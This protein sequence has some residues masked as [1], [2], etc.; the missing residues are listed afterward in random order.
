VIRQM[1]AGTDKKELY[2]VV[3]RYKGKLGP[4]ATTR[5]LNEYL[6]VRRGPPALPLECRTALIPSPV[7][8]MATG[9]LPRPRP[10]V[11]I[12]GLPQLGGQQPTACQA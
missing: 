10:V 3:V 8:P 4:F 11:L 2:Q 5:M 1:V 6:K 7:A 12:C 9:R